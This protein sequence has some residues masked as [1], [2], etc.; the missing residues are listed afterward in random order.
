V[1]EDVNFTLRGNLTLA[2]NNVDYWEQTYVYPY[3]ANTGYPLGVYRGLVA[4]GLFKDEEDVRSSPK[5]TFMEKVLPGD[6]KYK[7]V[8][9]DGKIDNDDQVPLSF[10][11]IPNFQYGFA[12]EF[13]YKNFTLST[14]FE[15]VSEV[16][17]QYGGT[18]YYPYA[19]ETRGNLLSIAAQQS[20][21]WTPASYSGTT[22]TENPNARFPRLTYGDN[23]NN[24]RSSTFWMADGTYLRLK[25]VELTYRLPK[26]FVRRL[27]LQGITA[28]VI[29]DNLHVWDKVKLWD[30]AQASTNGGVYP[31]QR[32]Y[33]FQLYVNF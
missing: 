17:F 10:S 1:N 16:Q 31:L 18:G 5:Q 30:P 7:D 2:R 22:D 12:T 21:R 13:S 11:N 20:N 6:I 19:W 9:G 28:S 26:T 3:Q 29:G 4:L 27:G 14:F 15:G 32:M 23:P 33:T 8:N 25:N 24:N